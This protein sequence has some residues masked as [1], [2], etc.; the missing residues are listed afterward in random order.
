MLAYFENGEKCES[1]FELALIRCWNTLKTAGNLTVK[2][3]CK[4]LLPKECTYTLRIDQS[5]SKSVEKYSVFIISSFQTVPFPNMSVRAPFSKSAGKKPFRFCVNGRPILHIFHRIQTVP[6]S[7]ERSLKPLKRGKSKPKRCAIFLGNPVV[8]Y[9]TQ[10]MILSCCECA[11]L[12]VSNNSHILMGKWDLK[13]YRV[14]QKGGNA[15]GG[16]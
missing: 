9:S 10:N 16:L 11:K 14:C 3:R 8:I 5:R 13:Y 7:C 6:T 1:K 15:F 4:T 2:T 12:C